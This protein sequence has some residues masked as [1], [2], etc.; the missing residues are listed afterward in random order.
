[1]NKNS[2]FLLGIAMVVIIISSLVIL[3]FPL[4]LEAKSSSSSLTIIVKF[5]YSD[6]LK[7]HPK[8]I[9]KMDL[10]VYSDQDEYRKYIDLSKLP[11]SKSISLNVAVNGQFT[12]HLNSYA[13]DDGTQVSGINGPEREPETVRIRVP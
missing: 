8:E 13:R 3:V 9:G 6:Y 11:K 7:K 4:P 10:Y 2:A 12:V 5:Q 1:M